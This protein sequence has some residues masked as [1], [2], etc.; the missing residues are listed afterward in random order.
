MNW[1]I[2]TT[3]LTIL[4]AFP[5]YAEHNA[6]YCGSPTM[7]TRA[8]DDTGERLTWVL[9]VDYAVITGDSWQ[10][11]YKTQKAYAGLYNP[12]AKEVLLLKAAKATKANVCVRARWGGGLT[13]SKKISSVGL[14]TDSIER[15]DYETN[16]DPDEEEN[17]VGYSG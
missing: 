14:I 10:D 5:A 4:S 8:K 9:I 13:S 2:L 12:T 16:F 6:T 3:L 7:D 17:M 1:K 15:L 11:Q